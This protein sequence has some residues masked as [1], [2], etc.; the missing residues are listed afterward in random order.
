MSHAEK[1]AL[2][3]WLF[4][5]LDALEGRLGEVERTVKKTSQNSSRPQS[6]D[7]LRRQAAYFISTWVV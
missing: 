3:L 2:I 1:D 5:V 4:D 7:G 6:S